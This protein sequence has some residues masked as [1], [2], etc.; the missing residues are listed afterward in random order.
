MR[1]V[2]LTFVTTIVLTLALVA[3]LTVG[4]SEEPII[5]RSPISDDPSLLANAKPITCTYEVL[6][7]L[8]QGL[9]SQDGHGHGPDIGSDEWF[10]V[11]EF[12]LDIQSNASLPER[13]TD[14]W[15]DYMHQQMLAKQVHM[16]E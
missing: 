13:G 12:K 2:N 9:S 7:K 5:K 3:L 15:C 4:C 1:S 14:K 11:I 8:E 6:E 16:A 10:G